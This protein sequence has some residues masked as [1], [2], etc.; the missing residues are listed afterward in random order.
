LDIC[1]ALPFDQLSGFGV[2]L[3]FHRYFTH[4]HSK[5]SDGCRPPGMDPIASV[6]FGQM[7]K[8]AKPPAIHSSCRVV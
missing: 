7:Q 1:L 6:R 5:P 3:G 4:G 8:P 2:T